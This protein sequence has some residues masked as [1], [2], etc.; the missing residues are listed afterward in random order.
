MAWKFGEC[1][2]PCIYVLAFLNSRA[3]I[4]LICFLDILISDEKPSGGKNNLPVITESSVSIVVLSNRLRTISVDV[5]FVESRLKYM[6]W[7]WQNVYHI[8]R[9]FNTPIVHVITSNQ[10]HA[11]YSVTSNEFVLRETLSHPDSIP[12]SFHRFLSRRTILKWRVLT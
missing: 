2:I 1:W 9:K 5:I 10:S 8:F 3:D 12:I 7:F 6:L 11:I 4:Y